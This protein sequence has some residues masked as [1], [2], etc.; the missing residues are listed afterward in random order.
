M[1]RRPPRSTRVRSSAASD[2]YK[3]QGYRAALG[4]SIPQNQSSR[5]LG[6]FWAEN[7]GSEKQHILRCPHFGDNCR[8]WTPKSK[9]PGSIFCYFFELFG[10]VCPRGPQTPQNHENSMIFRRFYVFFQR[11]SVRFCRYAGCADAQ[12]LQICMCCRYADFAFPGCLHFCL[13]LLL[14]RSQTQTV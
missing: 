5:A 6:R 12:D 14:L 2:V 7:A 4:A 13:P 11:F 10:K 3:R 8:K 9:N 1:I